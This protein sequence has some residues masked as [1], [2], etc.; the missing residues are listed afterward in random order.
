LGEKKGLGGLLRGWVDFLDRQESPFKVNIWKNLSQRFAMNLTYQ[1][2]SIYLASLGASPLI[3]GYIGSI[4]G[5]INTILAIPTGVLADRIG[6]RKVLLMTITVSMI[7]GLVFAVSGSWEVAAVAMALSGVAFVLDRTVCPMICGSILASHERVT[8]MGICDTISFFPQLIAPIIGATLITYFGGMNKT[9]I[10]PLYYLQ[11]VGY[12]VAF[13]IILLKFKNPSSRMGGRRETSVIQDLRTVLK[14]GKLVPRWLLLTIFAGFPAQ[15]LFYIP[16]FAAE[17]KGANQFI[18]GGMSTA[19]TLVFVFFAVPM[20]HMA[21]TYGRKRV[22]SA[23]T[24]TVALSYFVLVWSPNN[25]MLLLSAF[26][27]GFNMTVVQSQ[28]AISVDL[29]PAKYLGSWY[30]VQGFVKGFIGIIAPIL[31]GYLWDLVSPQSIFYILALM[32][33]SALAVLLTFP[34]EIT[35]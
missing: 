30:G 11:V 9:G 12:A 35:R 4:N 23:A 13:M 1:Y 20:G 29:V 34:T 25:Y 14:E 8:G 32:Q 22:V 5:I 31:C 18:V 24:L 27:S 15:V 26:M 17:I 10:R 21:D 3:L 16:L 28:M 33:V 2:Q 19:S 7:S 6:I